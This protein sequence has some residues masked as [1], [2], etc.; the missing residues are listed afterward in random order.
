MPTAD[1]MLSAEA[2]TGLARCLRRAGRTPTAVRRSVRAL[3]GTS[4]SERGQLVRDALL[5]DLPE[6]YAEVDALLRTAL[7]DPEFTGWMIWPVTEAVARRALPDSF[8]AGMDLLAALTPRL[9]AEFAIRTF[10]DA[11]LDRGLARALEWTGHPDEH[12]RR[13][14]SEGTRPRLPW[15]RRVRAILD[16]PEC[17]VPVLDALHADESEYVRRSVANHLNDISRGDPALAVRTAGRWQDTSPAVVRHAL[18][19]LVK[20]G[21]PEA[22][23][24]LGFR[25]VTGLTVTGP[26]LV[27]AE[28]AM[29]GR[30]DFSFSLTNTTAESV[31]LA[32]DYVIG[33]RKANGTLSPKVFKLTTRVLDPGASVAVTRSHSFRPISTRVYYPG[34]HTISLQVNGTA[35]EAVSFTLS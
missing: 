19:T 8:D 33:H 34:E 12:V 35:Y 27:A 23:A 24:L 1:E 13:L 7:A 30:L 20:Q 4:F 10:L 26:E 14:A 16:R 15:A 21:D 31:R 6:R 11:D 17:T 5:A 9:T 2:V 18:R 28:V 29:G 25:P 3:P 22:L 32:V